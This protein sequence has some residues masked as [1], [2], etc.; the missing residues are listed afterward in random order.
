[1][2]AAIARHVSRIAGPND[3]VDGRGCPIRDN[4]DVVYA[5]RGGNLKRGTVWSIDGNKVYVRV[6]RHAKGQNAYTV[7]RADRLLV[8]IFP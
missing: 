5:I 3:I 7:V 6:A 1:M 8:V 4:D 2:T